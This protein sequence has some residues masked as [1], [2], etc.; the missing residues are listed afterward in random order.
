MSIWK[1]KWFQDFFGDE[2]LSLRKSSIFSIFSIFSK[3]FDFLKDFNA[4]KN[5]EIFHPEKKTEKNI[6]EKKIK[7]P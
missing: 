4:K 6:F 1:K 7:P 5:P 2:K 3:I